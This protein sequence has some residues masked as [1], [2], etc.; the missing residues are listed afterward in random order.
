MV[1][2]TQAGTRTC[3]NGAVSNGWLMMTSPQID[4]SS[5][6]ASPDEQQASTNQAIEDRPMDE[7]RLMDA[8]SRR[9]KSVFSA[10]PS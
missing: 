9:E 5:P 2:C 6:R 4:G 10:S 8:A 3:R 1:S 7:G